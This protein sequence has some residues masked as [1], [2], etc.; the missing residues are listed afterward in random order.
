MI[1][2]DYETLAIKWILGDPTKKWHQFPSL[3]QYALEFAPGTLPPIG[4]HAV[5]ITYDQNVMV[6]DNGKDSDIQFPVGESRD[7]S[8]PRKYR[9]DLDSKTATEVWNYDMDQTVVSGIC[10]GV[11]EDQP[12][13]YLIDY[14]DVNGPGAP[15]QYVQFL[16]LDA[17]GEK[18]F[19]YQYANHF[20]IT[21]FNVLPRPTTWKTL[22][23]QRS[24]RSR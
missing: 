7:Y 9:I 14:A 24:D 20:C 19:Y 15:V 6:F 17:S 13:N 10:S 3:A 2:L 22:L 16:G 23:S 4:Q 8:S 21:A 1:C 18:V 5:S 12:L 11:Y